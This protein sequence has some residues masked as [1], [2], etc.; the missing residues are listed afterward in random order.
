[1]AIGNAIGAFRPTLAI[2]NGQRDRRRFPLRAADEEELAANFANERE[3]N[4]MIRVFRVNS[5]L[6]FLAN[7]QLLIAS[8]LG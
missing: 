1:M 5:R 8:C 6:A 2:S 3:S 4:E 7:Y